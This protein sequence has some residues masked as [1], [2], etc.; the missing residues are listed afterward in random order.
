[1]NTVEQKPDFSKPIMKIIAVA[2][3]AIVIVAFVLTVA[4]PYLLRVNITENFNPPPPSAQF[5]F[6]SKSGWT[7]REGGFLGIGADYVVYV[8]ATIKNIGQTGG[9]CVVNVKVYE[10]DSY[11]TKSE[12]IYLSVS[13][14][15]TVK[16]R[17]AE[18]ISGP[19]RYIVWI[20]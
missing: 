19:A 4:I 10:G 16:F 14:Q 7:T 20:S 11:W 3:I 12:S 9:G 18:P 1:M 6:L 2:A 13:E 5:T 17:F 8:E 15:K